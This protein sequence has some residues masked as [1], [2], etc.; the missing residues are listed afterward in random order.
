MVRARI[1]AVGPPS[2]TP[3]QSSF[4]HRP[5][6]CSLAFHRGSGGKQQASIPVRPFCA[7]SCCGWCGAVDAADVRLF[8]WSF[9][10]KFTRLGWAN[11]DETLRSRDRDITVATTSHQLLSR[12]PDQNKSLPVCGPSHGNLLQRPNTR[13]VAWYVHVRVAIGEGTPPSSSR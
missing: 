3:N 6:G 7:T 11:S 9:G 10:R 1:L 4:R 8:Y 12:H 2:P 13:F 5:S